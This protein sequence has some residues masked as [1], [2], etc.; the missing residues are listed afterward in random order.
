MVQ[1]IGSKFAHF[2]LMSFE[3]FQ[4][5]LYGAFLVMAGILG[6]SVAIGAVLTVLWLGS[7][8]VDGVFLFFQ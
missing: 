5:F 6:V 2:F 4:F 3:V 7:A 1:A 8:L